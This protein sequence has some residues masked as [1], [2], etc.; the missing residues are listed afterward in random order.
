MF[1]DH[2]NRAAA[3]THRYLFPP[4]PLRISPAK[5]PHKRGE[6]LPRLL[7]RCCQ[8]DTVLRQ[9]VSPMQNSTD[10]AVQP[11]I[12]HD[13]QFRPFVRDPAFECRLH[14]ISQ[15]RR[16]P[17][18]GSDEVFDQDNV[19][20]ALRSHRMQRGMGL[21]P[22]P[23]DASQILVHALHSVCAATGY[24]SRRSFHVFLG[25]RLDH[26]EQSDVL[27]TQFS[28]ELDQCVTYSRLELS[29][30]D[31][32]KGAQELAPNLPFDKRELF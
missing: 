14:F 9:A 16:D 21:N 31:E 15:I 27:V 18:S 30:R 28:K 24:P 26:A 17:P 25:R 5:I 29:M 32:T 2:A 13:P 4:R 10:A 22:W 1:E 7:H 11:A 20:H 6:E 23:V 19:L 8:P 3:K 12:G